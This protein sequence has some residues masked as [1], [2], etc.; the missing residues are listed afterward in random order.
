M[1]LFAET[2]RDLETGMQS[3]VRKRKTNIYQQIYICGMQKNGTDELICKAEIETDVRIP[4][5][6]GGA[7]M[8][9]EIGIDIYIHN[10]VYNR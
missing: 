6:L 10:Y 2:W 8:N 7:R 3:E 5:E 9:Q 4:R 1:V